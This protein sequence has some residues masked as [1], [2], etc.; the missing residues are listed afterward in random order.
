MSLLKLRKLFIVGVLFFGFSVQAATPVKSDVA[1]S[2]ASIVLATVNIQN[3]TIVSQDG[4]TLS[5]AFDFTN[6][7]GVQPHVRYSVQLVSGTSDNQY[8]ADEYV[9][10]DEVS[11]AE[12]T[13]LH[14]NITY[15]VPASI[16]GTY[17]VYLESANDAGTP[18]GIDDVGKVTFNASA[19]GGVELVAGTCFL[20]IVGEKSSPK[21]S[22]SQGVDIKKTE[23]LT[24][25][26][27]AVNNAKTPVTL[28]PHFETHN[29][30]P[31]G[32]VVIAN[33]GDTA[34]VTLQAS[35]T[36]AL[37]FALPKA[38]DPQS[39]DVLVSLTGPQTSNSVDVHYVLQGMSA[40]IQT[41][42]LDKAYYPQGSTA[43]LSFFWS[44]AADTFGGSRAGT[45][46]PSATRM[47]VTLQDASG[48]ACA[49]TV[50]QPLSSDLLVQI[51]LPIIHSC[52]NPHVTIKLLAADDAVLATGELVRPSP[53]QILPWAAAG[54]AVLVV[55]LIGLFSLTYVKKRRGVN[56]T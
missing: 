44:P 47:S 25:H 24:L 45:S 48:D 14:Q 22:L 11:L 55:I 30:S 39:Y 51:L 43:A 29:R 37:A 52:T 56:H 6:R 23:N 54:V 28:T 27:S 18:L 3:A 34:P 4:H 7:Q 1:P 19:T 8:I 35:E 31:Y 49:T 46:S 26:C 40:T 42:N 2:S 17:E 33:G 10:P 16:Q 32:D 38:A 21:Y 12:N 53:T 20:Q 9:Y 15:N 5:I 36:K 50:S 41:I 13:T